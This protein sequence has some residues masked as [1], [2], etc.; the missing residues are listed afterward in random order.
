MDSDEDM[1]EY[2]RQEQAAYLEYQRKTGSSAARVVR[3]PK[4]QESAPE[5]KPAPTP[6]PKP[7]TPTL[8]VCEVVEKNFGEAVT[9]EPF[10]LPTVSVPLV[11]HRN[12]PRA[13]SLG[14]KA[15]PAPVAA[16][17]VSP[18]NSK[19]PRTLAEEIHE[20]NTKTI[21]E[22]SA[23]EIKEAQAKLLTSMSPALVEKLRR[24]AR[25]KDALH[26]DAPVDIV[27]E[28]PKFV[29]EGR[30]RLFLEG[31]QKKITIKESF[32]SEKEERD[33]VKLDFAPKATAQPAAKK[34]SLFLQSQQGSV[35]LPKPA[36]KIAPEQ[37]QK[38]LPSG[39]TPKKSNSQDPM[40]DILEYFGRP[41]T[42]DE[43]AAMEWMSPVLPKVREEKAKVTTQR[44]LGYRFDL[45]GNLLSKELMSSLP[46]HQGLHHHG[47]DPDLA[48]YTILELLHLAKSTVP[49]QVII[50]MRTLSGL[51]ANITN[52][53]SFA[54][55]DGGNILK[56]MLDCRLGIVLRTNLDNTNMNIVLQTLRCIAILFKDKASAKVLELSSLVGDRS[57]EVYPLSKQGE[58]VI[59][60]EDP[61]EDH[62]I[63]QEEFVLGLLKTGLLGRLRYLVE[64]VD[65]SDE[66]MTEVFAIFWRSVSNS[67]VSAN[68]F[69]ECP[70][71]VDLLKSKYLRQERPVDEWTCQTLNI[72]RMLCA[73]DYKYSQHLFKTKTIEVLLKFIVPLAN[74]TSNL[75]DDSYEVIACTESLNI[76][77]I[78]WRYGLSIST[79]ID[80]YQLFVDH[81]LVCLASDAN[82]VLACK[83]FE[84]LDGLEFRCIALEERLKSE[85]ASAATQ[86]EELQWSHLIPFVD[87][88][89][90]V[91][92]NIQKKNM[93]LLRSELLVDL[94]AKIF[95]FISTH[96]KG[97]SNYLEGSISEEQLEPLIDFM[98]SS[99]IVS[100]A[101][102]FITAPQPVEDVAKVNSLSGRASLPNLDTLAVTEQHLEQQYLCPSMYLLDEQ[103]IKK[104]LLRNSLVLGYLRLQKEIHVHIYKGK[105]LGWATHF[106]SLLKAVNDKVRA[107]SKKTPN[108][109]PSC[110]ESLLLLLRPSVHLIYE[111]IITLTKLLSVRKSQELKVIFPNPTSIYTLIS[112]SCLTIM[113]CFLPGDEVLVV[114]LLQEFKEI[115]KDNQLTFPAN[116]FTSA[117]ILLAGLKASNVLV[118]HMSYLEDGDLESFYLPREESELPLPYDWLF[119]LFHKQEEGLPSLSH[120]QTG[121]QALLY[122]EKSKNFYISSIPVQFRFAHVIHIYMLENS[123]FL[124]GMVKS[125]IDKLLQ[126][127][128]EQ[129]TGWVDLERVLGAKYYETVQKFLEV[130]LSDSFGDR[131][132]GSC[133]QLFMQRKLP[134]EIKNL[135][136]APLDQLWHLLLPNSDQ[137]NYTFLPLETLLQPAEDSKEVLQT[138]FKCLKVNKCLSFSWEQI[139]GSFIYWFLVHHVNSSFWPT[140]KAEDSTRARRTGFTSVLRD[141]KPVGLVYDIFFYEPQYKKGLSERDFIVS[142]I[143]RTSQAEVSEVRKAFLKELV[144]ENK[145]EKLMKD[146]FPVLAKFL[147]Q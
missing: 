12:D 104:V 134:Q 135:V 16:P 82:A 105:Q 35:A 147:E 87:Q 69:W 61:K 3:R 37:P 55:N 124:D 83:I 100:E 102:Q 57:Y 80:L 56:F 125:S 144:T 54:N 97:V 75:S 32:E 117:T 38:F 119:L 139:R 89:V 103:H 111:S 110:P 99:E 98:K 109:L 85:D 23:E 52:S 42:E 136:W 48:G 5:N 10:K 68:Y 17:A 44:V 70:G 45:N 51:L 81:I 90:Q 131:V 122:L 120:I 86:L 50:S 22:M 118:N 107:V 39:T 46:T 15:T 53:A 95:Q 88:A 130:F 143:E 33:Q 74:N 73:S 58:P 137:G 47:D 7:P 1:D 84:L 129:T 101:I 79:F 43:K 49:G 108:G 27:E 30:D 145:L 128:G 76:L 64:V 66:H 114:S 28:P 14:R 126:R 112:D 36:E 77:N 25:E 34:P 140:R 72:F 67:S 21:S 8:M 71:L 13:F 4:I 18:L 11:L 115:L 106:V 127:Y 19:G 65:V 93:P 113:S 20:Q 142:N 59:D 92:Q 96:V 29:A 63:M 132:Q 91:L 6:A 94:T 123:I 2:V 41:L 62:D 138:Y 60:E 146:E 40:E 141:L 78:W 9:E 24:K 31:P 116:Y 133:L 121:L 26:G